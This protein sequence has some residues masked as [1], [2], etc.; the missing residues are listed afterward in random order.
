MVYK[1]AAMLLHKGNE[2]ESTCSCDSCLLAQMRSG[3]AGQ[4][5]LGW[6]TWYERDAL[7][8]FAYLK[9]RC[10]ELGCPE[11]SEELVQD[12]FIVGFK[13]ISSGRFADKG[14]PLR[15][16][17]YGIAKN[18]LREVR[19]LRNK[20][21]M[22][23]EGNAAEPVAVSLNLLDHAIVEQVL[24]MIRDAYEHLPLLAQ[25]VITGLYAHGNTSKELASQLNKKA[26]AVGNIASRAIKRIQW[27]LVAY[28][29]MQLSASTI[30]FCFEEFW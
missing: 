23:P 4:R 30:R 12:C 16:Y 10:H 20:E 26:S 2:Y 9:R 1:E 24:T 27:Y 8:I 11:Q 13:N 14:K 19:W 18:L 6:Q 5:K 17:L 28:Y 21:S 29:D 7:S 15:A 3:D 22:L 25:R